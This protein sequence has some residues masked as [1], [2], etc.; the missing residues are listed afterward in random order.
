MNVG[1]LSIIIL[2]KVKTNK[3]ID[4]SIQKK[5]REKYNPDGSPLRDYQLQLLR[6]LK[7]FDE[8]CTVHDIRYWLSSG[9]CLGAVRHGGFIPWDDDV[10]VE[11]MREDYLKLIKLFKE[12]DKYVIQTWKNDRYYSF[13]FAK[14]RDKSSIIYNSLYKYK[15]C[16][17]DIFALEKTNRK[18]SSFSAYLH[19][20][21]SGYLY[22]FLKSK[23]EKKTQLSKIIFGISSGLFMLIKYSYFAVIPFIRFVGYLLPNKKLRHQYGVGWVDNIRNEENIF[24]IK[25]VLFEGFM[26]PVPGNYHKYLTNIYGNYSQIPSEVELPKSHVQYLNS[27]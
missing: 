4:I 1:S 18:L 19:N 3:M 16:F 25:R 10:D 23:S 11:M 5:L 26:L 27:K 2:E 22:D 9:T 7:D 24:P 17:I 6:M 14:L 15:G 13:S 21:F 8:F 12:T 20:F